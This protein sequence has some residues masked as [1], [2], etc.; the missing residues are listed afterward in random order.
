MEKI[1]V[2]YRNYSHLFDEWVFAVRKPEKLFRE[3]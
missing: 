2:F 1:I 3:K